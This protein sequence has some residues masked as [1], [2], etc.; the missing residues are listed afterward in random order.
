MILYCSTIR[1]WFWSSNLITNYFIWLFSR[2]ASSS[3]VSQYWA[4]LNIKWKSTPDHLLRLIPLKIKADTWMGT[5]QVDIDASFDHAN[6]TCSCA[7]FPQKH[8]VIYCFI[9]LKKGPDVKS[10]LQFCESQ[11]RIKSCITLLVFQRQRGTSCYSICV[12]SPAR[13]S[14]VVHV[15]VRV[16]KPAS[17]TWVTIQA[18]KVE[19]VLC[20]PTSSNSGGW[21]LSTSSE[22]LFFLNIYHTNKKFRCCNSSIS[23]T[24]EVQPI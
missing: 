12:W 10:C 4:I 21:W 6:N 3:Y 11:P 7:E 23:H 2:L 9:L 5:C 15:P 20:L 22:L 8:H 14:R 1:Y 17:W 16:W 19:T 18:A 24:E 13:W